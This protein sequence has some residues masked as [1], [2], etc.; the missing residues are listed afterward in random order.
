MFN[1]NCMLQTLE[2]WRK[3]EFKDLDISQCSFPDA[4]CKQTNGFLGWLELKGRTLQMIIVRRTQGEFNH[5]YLHCLRK[6]LGRLRP[7][8][9][10]LHFKPWSF[11]SSNTHKDVDL[12]GHCASIPAESR[13][14][15]SSIYHFHETTLLRGG[16]REFAKQNKSWRGLPKLLADIVCVMNE[17]FSLWWV[18]RGLVF[19]VLLI[20]KTTKFSDSI[21]QTVNNLS[22]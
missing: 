3:K 9:D 4:R 1:W 22:S 18:F 14:H 17:K 10:N 11:D 19:L 15:L 5:F 6:V 2:S 8:L 16:E 20:E 7:F 13:I 21:A 12:K